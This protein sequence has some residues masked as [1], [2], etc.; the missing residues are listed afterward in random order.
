[1]TE[2]AAILSAYDRAKADHCRCVLATVVHVEGSAYRRAGARMLVDEQGAMTGAISGGCLEG[3]ALR[4][5][6]HALHREQKKLVTYDTT[7]EEDAVVGAQLGCEGVIQVLFEPLPFDRPDNPVELLRKAVDSERPVALVSVFSLPP[8]RPQVGT[9]LLLDESGVLGAPSDQPGLPAIIQADARQAL[10]Q[11]TSYCGVYA[12]GQYAFIDVVLP[13]PTLVL[14][15]AGNDA[16]RLYR[17]AELLGWQVV[18][19]DGRPTHANAERFVGSCQVVVTKPES[20]LENIPISERTVFV[21]LT[22]NYQYDLAVLKLLLDQPSVPYI[23]IL[24]PKKKY[25]RMLDDLAEEGIRL[26]QEQAARIYAPVGLELGA[27]TPAEIGLSILSEIQAV[28]TQSNTRHLRD[29]QGP[30]HDDR[31][32]ALNR[33]KP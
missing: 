8:S 28:L 9:L 25:H 33:I 22:H 30:I 12:D 13:P 15:G 2:A 11:R 6:L 24:G 20:I 19:A 32:P 5:A 26:D 21:L 27:E 10:A 3:D 31:Q 16:Q 14:V 4:K 7:D 17:M 23:G 1:M 18:V 29:R